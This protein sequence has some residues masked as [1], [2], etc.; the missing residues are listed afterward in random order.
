MKARI[1]SYK[2]PCQ[3]VRTERVSNLSALASPLH[4]SLTTVRAR[5]AARRRSTERPTAPRDTDAGQPAAGTTRWSR[6]T[7]RTSPPQRVSRSEWE[8][9]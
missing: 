9:V 8:A 2:H 7:A 3:S 5:L 4:V 6:E 1:A